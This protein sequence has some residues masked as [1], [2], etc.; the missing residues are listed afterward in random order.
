VFLVGD[1]AQ[2]LIWFSGH[3]EKIINIVKE[4]SR[5]DKLDDFSPEGRRLRQG[6]EVLH[7]GRLRTKTYVK[8][9]F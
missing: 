1:L 5:F 2:N 6:T 3:A 8:E 7:R 9:D 4:F